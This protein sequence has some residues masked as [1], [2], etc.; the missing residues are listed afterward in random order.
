[1]EENT[2]QKQSNATGLQRHVSGRWISNVPSYEGNEWSSEE[3][4][5]EDKESNLTSS[6]NIGKNPERELN[7]DGTDRIIEEEEEEDDIENEASS[8]SEQSENENYDFSYPGTFVYRKAA[9]SSHETLAT[10]VVS[11][12]ESARLWAE[13]RRFLLQKLGKDPNS[14]PIDY[15]SSMA[16][17]STRSSQSSQVSA[18]QP[19]SQ[20]DNRVSDIRQME[21]RRELNVK[22]RS[23][24][25]PAEDLAIR[26]LSFSRYKKAEEIPESLPPIKGRDSFSSVR[27]LNESNVFARA[28][29]KNR[30]SFAS[31]AETGSGSNFSRATSS[32]SSKT[33]SV[34]YEPNHRHTSFFGDTLS[35]LSSSLND[36]KSPNDDHAVLDSELM[37]Q[38]L[39]DSAEAV[40]IANNVK[41]DIVSTANDDANEL[42]NTSEKATLETSSKP[43]TEQAIEQSEVVQEVEEGDTNMTTNTILKPTDEIINK[44]YAYSITS[45]HSNH[46]NEKFEQIPSPDE[47]LSRTDIDT[48]VKQLQTT[49]STD[50]LSIPFVESPQQ[51]PEEELSDSLSNDFG[52]DAEKEKDENLSK[53]EHHPSITSVNSPFLYSPSKQPSGEL[54]E[55][56]LKL[57]LQDSDVDDE[58]ATIRSLKQ[59][60][61]T[62]SEVETVTNDPSFSQQPGTH[63]RILRNFDAISSIDSIPDSFS[64][65]AVDL[66]V[67]SSKYTLVG[68]TQ[69]NSNLL[70]DNAE[71]HISKSNLE[72]V[73]VKGDTSPNSVEQG[74]EPQAAS[75][76]GSP[77]S[78]LV[79]NN[80]LE[81]GALLKNS[82][83][84]ESIYGYLS[85][86]PDP[87]LTKL[88]TEDPF[89]T[90]GSSDD[91]HTIASVEQDVY[92][93]KTS[94]PTIVEATTSHTE[95]SNSKAPAIEETTTTKVEVVAAHDAVSIS[96]NSS[97]HKSHSEPLNR[98]ELEVAALSRGSLPEPPKPNKQIVVQE[99]DQRDTLSLKTSTTGLSSHS[100]SAENNS[101]QQST[102]SP[103]INS[104][105]SADAVS[106]GISKKADNSETNLNYFATLDAFVKSPLMS[107]DGLG[108]LGSTDQRY[109]FFNQKIQEYS[110]Y[111]SG[112]DNWIQFCLE[113]D[114]EAPKEAPPPPR[115]E[116]VSTTTKLA[117]RITQPSLSPARST[118]TITHNI[119]TEAKKKSKSAAN[120]ILHLFKKKAKS[121]QSNA[122]SSS[123]S[124]KES[125]KMKTLFGK[126]L[127]F[128]S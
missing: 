41:E 89:W 24:S 30:F 54:D 44:G 26:P 36:K 72:K 42:D 25:S 92:P 69:S 45:S 40:E 81:E 110:A 78:S 94:L 85:E 101:T 127:G 108:E 34:V 38:T 124:I 74:I 121:E 18:I 7:S 23:V 2:A 96:S 105:A 82:E 58:V 91:E 47:K 75:V 100:K 6:E 115:S 112:L 49:K 16:S 114:G 12:D 84:L 76:V 63:S 88:N 95:S 67:D 21:N 56:N 116:P 8:F 22:R 1:M 39:P 87:A 109:N 59:N 3:S 14:K 120:D 97:T 128:K 118:V 15:K 122:K 27:E 32:R 86:E 68:K 113:K 55:G 48:H 10:K 31:V 77:R 43:V 104:G 28:P 62:N 99:E 29:N 71:K 83:S 111:D 103:S 65:S 46:S 37:E 17:S 126:K 66:P 79:S 64:D 13:K 51:N 19:Q 4:E 35:N 52:I 80:S 33:R 60:N 57:R 98:D 61:A 53:P 117:K 9:S 125:K 102:T 20:D 123:S 50:S 93:Y 107:F 90:K 70:Q 5:S 11:A 119:A 106:S 73:D